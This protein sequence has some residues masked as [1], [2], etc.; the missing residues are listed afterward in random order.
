MERV[1]VQQPTEHSPTILV[2]EDGDEYVEVMTRFLPEYRYAQVHCG[3][4]AIDYLGRHQVDAMF[5][6]MR[7]DRIE[8][9]R[10][11]GDFEHF[12]QKF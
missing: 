2:I 12:L 6:D 9:T 5:L 4:D 10:L 1:T 8:H 11:L 7:F 3:R